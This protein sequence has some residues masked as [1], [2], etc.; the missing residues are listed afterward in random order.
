MCHPSGLQLSF[1]GGRR[2]FTG[3]AER[4]SWH[5]NQPFGLRWN[6]SHSRVWGTRWSSKKCPWACQPLGTK[7]YPLPKVVWSISKL[8]SSCSCGVQT[9]VKC[10]CPET[11][12]LHAQN[13]GYSPHS[14]L[15]QW[16]TGNHTL[17]PSSIHVHLCG[18]IGSQAPAEILTSASS[19]WEK[20]LYEVF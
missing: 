8:G 16:K 4:L 6:H 7:A 18:F 19:K 9:F 15:A 20:L 11:L 10:I 17:H 13:Y 5:Q 3:T 14:L 1:A 2:S 12:V